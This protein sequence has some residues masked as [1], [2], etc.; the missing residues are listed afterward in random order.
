MSTSSMLTMSPA[1]MLTVWTTLL[2]LKYL[3]T[4]AL[5]EKVI[6]TLAA[7]KAC[8]YISRQMGWEAAPEH[9]FGCYL[10]VEV[11]SALQLQ[12]MLAHS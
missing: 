2:V 10:P 9:M 5:A 6:W 12:P 8:R 11:S 7:S 4:H 1:C 3:N